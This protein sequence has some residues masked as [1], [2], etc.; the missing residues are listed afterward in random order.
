MFSVLALFGA[1]L[2]WLRGSRASRD[3]EILVLRQQLL[4]L[5]RQA[6]ARLRLRNS[7]RL[8]FIWLYRLFPS[9]LDA[10]LIFKSERRCCKNGPG[11]LLL[12][13]GDAQT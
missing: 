1:L 4:I 2:A 6:P 11:G 7:D 9:L 10:V 13:C 12:T 5:R 3:A 8:I